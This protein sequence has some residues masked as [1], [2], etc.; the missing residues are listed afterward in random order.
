MVYQM[1][2]AD[3]FL[4]MLKLDISR[5]K[6]QTLTWSFITRHK[7]NNVLDQ[8]CP[9]RRMFLLYGINSKRS[10]VQLHIVFIL[11]NECFD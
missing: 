1:H 8:T 5:S 4:V 3:S 10:D 11:I 6:I 2:L 9:E 7:I